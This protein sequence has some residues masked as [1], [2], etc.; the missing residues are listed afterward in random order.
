MCSPTSAP[1]P[2]T[3][4][5]ASRSPSALPATRSA[6]LCR[7]PVR[8]RGLSADGRIR[9]KTVPA[10]YSERQ[11]GA[12]SQRQ[13]SRL[14]SAACGSG[15]ASEPGNG[16]AE[17]GSQQ[18]CSGCGRS[19]REGSPGLRPVASSTPAVMDSV[20]RGGHTQPLLKRR[21]R[22]CCASG[23]GPRAAERPRQSRGAFGTRGPVPFQDGFGGVK[24]GGL[25]AAGAAACGRGAVAVRPVPFTGPRWGR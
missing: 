1:Q 24:R 21:E 22:G 11:E 18:G 2:P 3:L 15:H 8:G 4:A 7:Q 12:R 6:R 20:P 10:G 5:L 25:S 16:P 13:C 14:R 23:T 19:Q 9:R 17:C